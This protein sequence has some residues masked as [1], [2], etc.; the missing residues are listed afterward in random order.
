MYMKVAE[1]FAGQRLLQGLSQNDEVEMPEVPVDKGAEI[2]IKQTQVVGHCRKRIVT[3]TGKCALKFT[4][5]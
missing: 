1:N 3:S 2:C 5:T 4:C